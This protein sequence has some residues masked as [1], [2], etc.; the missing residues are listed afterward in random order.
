MGF[1]DTGLDVAWIVDE[2]DENL[3]KDRRLYD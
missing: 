3:Q 1:S 2:K